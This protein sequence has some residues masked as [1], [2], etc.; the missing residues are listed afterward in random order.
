MDSPT[1]QPA[2]TSK[3]HCAHT[4][5]SSINDRGAIRKRSSNDIG[6]SIST[7][8][9]ERLFQLVTNT[10]DTLDQCS[11]TVAGVQWITPE[12]SPQLNGFAPSESTFGTFPQWTVPTPPRSDSGAPGVSIEEEPRLISSS[13]F[14]SF[15]QPVASEMSSLGFLLPSQY[16]AS[17]YESGQSGMVL[18]SFFNITPS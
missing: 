16:G 7:S 12:H 8:Q 14:E 4:L 10:T 5:T 11:T 17:P 3:T 9:A 13:G 18:I 2:L 1:I 6:G 15:N